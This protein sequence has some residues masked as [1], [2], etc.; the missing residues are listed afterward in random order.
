VQNSRLYRD[1]VGTC[2]LSR[3]MR[4]RLTDRLALTAILE[5]HGVRVGGC[6]LWGEWLHPMLLTPVVHTARGL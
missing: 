1:T 5:Q 2:R 3:H 6:M 4:N